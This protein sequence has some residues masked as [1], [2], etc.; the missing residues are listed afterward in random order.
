[1]GFF[2]DAILGAGILSFFQRDI[3]TISVGWLFH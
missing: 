3:V 1:V 2:D